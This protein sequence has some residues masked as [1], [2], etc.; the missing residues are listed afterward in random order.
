VYAITLES[1]GLGAVVFYLR[2][3][4]VTT[5]TCAFVSI[6]ATCS[7]RYYIS[8]SKAGTTLENERQQQHF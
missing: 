6:A 4:I 7:Y 1:S 5:S 3:V 8:P 2:F